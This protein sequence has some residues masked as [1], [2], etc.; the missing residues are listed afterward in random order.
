MKKFMSAVAAFAILC[1]ASVFAMASDC[2]EDAKKCPA[3]DCPAKKVEKKAG[4]KA[5]MKAR[6][7]RPR[8]QLSP[9]VKAEMENF[10]KAR[11]AYKKNPTPENKAKFA[12]LIG[13][14]FDKR[15]EMNKKRAEAMK[16]AVAAMEKRNAEMQANRDAEIEKMIQN[17]INPPKRPAKKQPAKKAPAKPTPAKT[18]PAPAPAAP[19]QK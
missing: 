15:L 11:E 8:P 19:A 4:K 5:E 3:K 12:E 10:R 16:K 14:R 17:S 2:P 1:S 6:P 13:K 18:A 7:R 9:E